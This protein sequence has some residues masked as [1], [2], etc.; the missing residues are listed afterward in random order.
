MAPKQA[1]LDPLASMDPAKQPKTPA[2]PLAGQSVFDPNIAAVPG[3]DNASLPQAGP[4]GANPDPNA[5]AA[6]PQAEAYTGAPTPTVGGIATSVPPTS[7]SLPAP[8]ASAV[9]PTDAMGFGGYSGSSPQLT[10]LLNGN[11]GRPAGSID[12]TTNTSASV[13]RQKLAMDPTWTPERDQ[14]NQ[15]A[16]DA[17]FVTDAKGNVY[18][19]GQAP[20]VQAGVPVPGTGG[21]PLGNINDAGFNLAALGKANVFDPTIGGYRPAT[22][23][24]PPPPIAGTDGGGADARRATL[25]ALQ[26]GKAAPPAPMQTAGAPGATTT[27][28]G[29]PPPAPLPQPAPV[30]A[31]P[32]QSP[33]AAPSGGGGGLPPGAEQGGTT[34]TTTGANIPGLPSAAPSGA[35]PAGGGQ[36]GMANVAQN[37]T[38]AENA[39]TNQTLSRA[40]GTDRYTQAQSQWDAFQKSTAPQYQADLRAAMQKAAA[41]GALGS[42]M[43]QSS[44]GDVANNRATQLDS[45]RQTLLSQ[46][47][48]NSIGDQFG[49]VGIAQQQQGFQRGQQQDAFGN[50]IQQA[51]TED[52]LTGNDFNRALQ[53]LQAGSTGNPADIQLVLSQIFGSQAT[54]AGSSLAQ[55]L[56]GM[57][58]RSTAGS[59]GTDL[60]TLIQQMLGGR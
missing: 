53:R 10:A 49:D 9:P 51:T 12:A 60:A 3:E 25:E 43:L 21:K 46:A 54:G 38:T 39:L 24:S 32:P 48:N 37:A 55:L 45:Q 44:L 58:Q 15:A 16:A 14:L 52:Q 17:G 5:Y 1:I 26:A 36:A 34:V 31:P 35:T 47:L 23:S 57:G 30:T 19:A 33:P 4:S 28:T 42:G 11:A 50:M 59:G 29:T 2:A 18:Q 56:G 40:P 41:G 20:A 8:Q 13:A 6:P 27:A 22:A 7:P